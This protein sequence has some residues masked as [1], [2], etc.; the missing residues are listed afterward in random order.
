MVVKNYSDAMEFILKNGIPKKIIFEK[1]DSHSECGSYGSDFI[2]WIIELDFE[3]IY[4]LPKK[5]KVYFEKLD[6]EDSLNIQRYLSKY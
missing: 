3:E 2:K 4:K 6:D 5:F 1:S